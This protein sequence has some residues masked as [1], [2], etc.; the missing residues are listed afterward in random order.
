MLL[1][2][3]AFAGCKPGQPPPN[4]DPDPTVDPVDCT[5]SVTPGT[6]L[7]LLTRAEYDLTVR[8]LLGATSKPAR[9]FP[10]EPMAHGLD[11][12][13][14]LNQVTGAHVAAYLDGAEFLAAD[15]LVNRRSTILP[16]TSNDQACGELFIATLGLKAFRRPLNAEERSNLNTLFTTLSATEGF[17][18]A[19]EVTLQSMLQSPQ[20]LY[21]DEQALGPVPVPVVTLGGYELASR[22]SYFL[23]GT[24]PDEQLLE[25]AANGTLDTPAG[26][27]AQ[28]RRMLADGKSV[29]GLM[30]F[31][32]LWLYL[33]GVENTEKN[34]AVYPQFSPAL[35][36]AWRTSLELF[37]QDVLAHEGTLTA[38]LSSN[39]MYTNDTMS[40]YG[41]SAPSSTFLRNEMPGTQRKG[42]LTQPGFLA[43]KAMPDGSS[44]VRRGIFVLDKLMCEPPPPPPAGANITP[45]QPSVTNTTRERFAAHSQSDGCAGCHKFIDPVGFTF[46][47]YDG[48][49]LWRDTE[50][51]QPI[52]ASG[53]VK[54]SRDTAVLGDVNGVA[55]LSAKLAGSRN[56]H[57]C[58]A[59]EFYRFALGRPLNQ[60]DTCTATLIGDR[61]MTSGGNFREL[62][63]AIVQ[64][65]AFRR[66]ANPEMT[67]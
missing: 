40:M 52:D 18:G 29:D 14:D 37:V 20:F 11:N 64:S 9:D 31:F 17:E 66:N 2:L 7:R 42:L 32:S 47:N 44:P 1:G 57:D 19:V 24:M 8:D 35:A 4:P 43:F 54:I 49:G 55:E 30:R 51:G 41:P 34:T 45:P 21:R 28:A 15:T 56:V 25:A 5:P 38:L 26:L 22:L 46:E 23:W 39:V 33:D 6:P 62:M 60:A 67:P 63:L 36:S 65:D 53:G 50:N 58:V 12:D 10:R 3:L 48:L 13:A 61:F 16:C 59:K 27:E